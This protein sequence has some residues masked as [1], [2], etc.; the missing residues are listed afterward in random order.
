MGKGY[1]SALKERIGEELYSKIVVTDR[2]HVAKLLGKIIDKERV[3]E[4]NKLKKEFENDSCML[5]SFKNTMWPY[6]S[7]GMI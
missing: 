4:M 5:D 3:K 6:R 2:F 7:I 1:I